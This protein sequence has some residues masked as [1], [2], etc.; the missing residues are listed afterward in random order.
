MILV[1]WQ[2]P[3]E[4]W[5]LAWIE[6][7]ADLFDAND[8]RLAVQDDAVAFAAADQRLRARVAAFAQQR[9]RE[10]QQPDLHP[11]C[12]KALNSLCNHWSGLTLF[13]D[14]PEV[15]M[16]NN[17]S[18]RCHRGPVV[19]R[20]NFYGSGAIWSGRLASML[21]SLLQTLALWAV[22]PRRWLT[23]YLTA[24][25]EAGGQV[26]PNWQK[27]LPWRM[28]KEDYH[29]WADPTAPPDPKPQTIHPS[30]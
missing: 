23:A 10:L 8:T 30:S 12:R 29:A 24:C 9:D 15:P 13:V 5:A 3:L 18:E 28:T 14:H 2:T 19:G 21:F 1:S 17:A 7:I 27:F 16:D 25:A 26:P 11:A 6:R 22:C 4:T 20:K